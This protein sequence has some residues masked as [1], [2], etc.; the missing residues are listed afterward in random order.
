MAHLDKSLV[1]PVLVGRSREIELLNQVLR[2]V[3]NG[4]GR[5]VLL[6]GEAGIGKSRLVNELR[7]RAVAQQFAILR[8]YC[9]EQDVSF[10][11]APWIDAL[12]TFLAPKSATETSQTLGT[13]A[14]ELV[15]LL[16]ELSL[17]VPSIQ[18][19]P[20]LDAASE[21]HRLFESLARFGASLAASNPLLIVLEDLHW[22]DESSLELLH[23][24]AR[25]F[26]VLP[27]LLIGTYR[28]E[29]IL[30]R[31][32]HYLTELNRE[33]LV[34][35]IRLAPLTRDEIEQMMRAVLKTEH[36]VASLLDALVRLTE[37]NPFF[38]EEILKTQ[39]LRAD[40]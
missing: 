12:R 1:L 7:S 20:P 38:V 23:F 33:R 34:E 14:S 15:K 19:T 26:S 29:E 25:R 2:A 27:I 18:A 31:L 17:L 22:S 11:Y 3:R 10:P 35:E 39:P 13:L 28:S 24:F 8:G 4:A 36:R 32:S 37:G 21:K 16:P 40:S 9:F 5:C 6:A 30:P